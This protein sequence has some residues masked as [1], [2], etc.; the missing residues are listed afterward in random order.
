MTPSPLVRCIIDPLLKGEIPHESYQGVTRSSQKESSTKHSLN[1]HTMSTRARIGILLKDLSVESVYHH[2]DGYPEWLG[3][4]LQEHYN[5]HES[6]AKL[7]NGGNMSSCYSDNEFDYEKQEFVKKDPAPSYY[8]G[9]DE[10][11]HLNTSIQE[12][13]KDAFASEE[14]L[15]LFCS[16]EVIKANE[17][18]MRHTIFSVEGWHAWSVRPI[19]NED[20]SI[21]NTDVTPVEIPAYDV[22]DAS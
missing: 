18:N 13:L 3:V 1:K 11:P 8:G 9:D 7:I 15:Y 5:T 4:T 21:R 12:F 16:E 22:A 2:W 6:V 14:Y 10:R 20:Y 19:Y 17:H